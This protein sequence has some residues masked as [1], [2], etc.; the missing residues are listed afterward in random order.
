MTLTISARDQVQ[1]FVHD[2]SVDDPKLTVMLLH[3]YGEH[4]ARYQHV[5]QAWN[6]R[7]IQVAAV[8]LRGHGRSQGRRGF[9]D[10]FEDYHADADALFEF[11]QDR[12]QGGPIA[13]V[14]HSMGGLL[15]IHWRLARGEQPFVGLALSSPFLG[16]DDPNP[17]KAAAGRLFSKVLPK[18]SLDSGLKGKDVCRDAQIADFYDHDPLNNKKANARWFTEVTKAIATAHDKAP[19]LTDPTSAPIRRGRPRR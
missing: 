1:L 15:A 16:L 12:A 5:A 14:G 19:Q 3:G 7:G 18:L 13:V 9:V 2:W 4:A 8:D 17:V 6:K 10:R 11:T